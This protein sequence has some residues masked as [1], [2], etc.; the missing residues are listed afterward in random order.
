M[1]KYLL[2]FTLA[3]YVLPVKT[4]SQPNKAQ[5]A[6]KGE[7]PTLPTATVV[8]QDGNSPSIQ[9]Q[10]NNHINA[11]VRVVSTPEKDGYERAAFWANIAL[12]VVGIGGIFVA[13]CTLK[14]IERQTQASENATKVAQE[15]MAA[16]INK[17]RARIRVEAPPKYL[18][19]L[20]PGY[21]RDTLE[22]KIYGGD[23]QVVELKI[24]NRGGTT[25]RDVKASFSLSI[26]P[27][28]IEE[29]WNVQETFKESMG[30]LAPS[31]LP[32]KYSISLYG[33]I[34]QEHLEAIH[35]QH[36]ILRVF[37]EITYTDAF[38]AQK[39]RTTSFSFE[40][41]SDYEW[42]VSSSVKKVSADASCW[43]EY[44]TSENYC[45]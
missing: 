36:A 29:D 25:A 31:D 15:N 7:K 33:G 16:V 19:F 8:P 27:V 41:K 39:T 12:V 4:H 40:W 20:Q 9:P 32:L 24:F 3:I 10:P 43:W 1:L 11:D 5:Q 35:S 6:S 22:H 45:T 13:V 14:K 18:E 17:E 44:P 28:S 38:E 21:L 2:I 26:S 30:D 23:S 42:H 34:N 37:G